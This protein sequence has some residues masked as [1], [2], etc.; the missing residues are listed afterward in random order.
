[1]MK[2]YTNGKIY[3]VNEKRDWAEAVVVDGEHIVFV[4]DDK[5]ASAFIEKEKTKGKPVE[6]IDLDGKLMLPGFIDGHC[7]TVMGAFFKTGI[8]LNGLFTLD[9]ML[10]EIRRYIETHPDKKYYSGKGFQEEY[11]I[12]NEILP[13]KSM[14]DSICEDTPIFIYGTSGHVAWCN[15]CALEK[16]G[17]TAD[18]PD[19]YPGLSYFGRDAEGNPT[20]YLVENMATTMVSD[21]VEVVDYEEVGRSMLEISEQYAVNGITSICDMG[22][23]GGMLEYMK[24]GLIDLIESGELKQRFN[25]CGRM[26][27]SIGE[28]DEGIALTQELINSEADIDQC[29][30]SF[31]K[32]FQDGTVE[33][34][35]AAISAPYLNIGSA[36]E[37]FFT[38]DEMVEAGLKIAEAGFDIN[39]HSRTCQNDAGAA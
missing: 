36:P 21:K 7:H 6:V 14:L 19:P 33:D 4:G 38:D 1:M 32:M 17:I 13:D 15:S 29:R 8:I 27:N 10:A 31:V 3:T 26:V 11:F 39:V 9:E 25:G 30:F 37:P 24:N 34:L 20:G 12:Q 23:I 2:A 35:T 18:T 28:V 22:G 5:G 16:A